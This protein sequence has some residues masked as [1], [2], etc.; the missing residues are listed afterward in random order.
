MTLQR[1]AAFVFVALALWFAWQFA[2]ELFIAWYSGVEPE[3]T[4]WQRAW[5]WGCIVML[6][7]AAAIVIWSFAS[8]AD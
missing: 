6:L 8:A 4:G 5:M 7:L 2:A 3:R 1:I